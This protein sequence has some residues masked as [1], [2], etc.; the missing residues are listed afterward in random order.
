[1]KKLLFS[2]FLIFIILT[3][4]CTIPGTDIEI[5]LPDIFSGKTEEMTHDVIVIDSIQAT[6][7]DEVRS[8]QSIRLLAYIKNKQKPESDPQE[9]VIVRLYNDC[10]IFEI[11]TECPQGQEIGD[12]SCK[13][14][15]MY[16]LSTA[17]VEWKLI[18]K[19]VNIK[20]PCEIGIYVEYEYKTHSTSSVTFVNKEEAEQWVLQGKKV[21]ESGTKVIGEGPIKSYVEVKSQPIMVDTKKTGEASGS[22]ILTFWI[23]NKGSGILKE[24]KLPVENIKITSAVEGNEKILASLGKQ[25]MSIDDCIKNKIRDSYIM[26]IGKKSPIY[27]CEIYLANPSEVKIESTY[28]INSNITYTYRVVKKKNIVVKPEIEL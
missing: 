20:T 9:N 15:R 28:Q 5:P 8:H 6:P 4:G 12:N 13:I 26:L 1:M 24:S 16:P 25:K 23:E 27:S 17:I 21:D 10:G 22:S 19:P 11:E 18:A 14:P 3:S 2:L 7:S